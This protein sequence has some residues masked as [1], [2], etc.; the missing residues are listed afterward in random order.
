MIVNFEFFD[1]DP[2]KNVITNLNYKIEK[3]V[4]FCNDTVKQEQKN[5]ITDFLQTVCAT[6]EVEF[7]EV[8]TFDLHAITEA[9]SDKVDEELGAGNQ[10]YFD[11]SGGDSLQLV[12]FGMVSKDLQVPMHMYD[13]SNGEMYEYGFEDNGH[14]SREVEYDPISL[15]LDEYIALYGGVINYRMHKSFKDTM[16]EEAAEDIVKTWKL[17]RKYSGK[18]V[19]Y[20]GLMRKFIPDASLHVQILGSQM[21][22]EAQKLKYVGSTNAF[23]KFLRECESL[24]LIVDVTHINSVFAFTYK[25]EAIKN[26]FWDSGSILEMYTFLKELEDDEVNDCRVG[27]H[28]DWDGEIHAASDE[29]V[30]NEIDVISMKNNQPTFISCKIGNV[31]QMALYELDAVASRF[32]GR[33]VKK[34]L[35]V[36]KEVSQSHQLRAK[37]M[38]IDI[39]FME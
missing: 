18:W 19:Y 12:A 33:S 21:L 14:M 35:S 25:T 36:A 5:S 23:K 8:D 7:C 10:V 20:C 22:K 32:G 24:G 31:D 1:N 28:I 16:D 27:V 30:L 38:G 17:S 11:M 26:Y 37:E 6:K 34:A 2:I 13:M 4:Y 9:I 39:R 15:N 3:T 29:D